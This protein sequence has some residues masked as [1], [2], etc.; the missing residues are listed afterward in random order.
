MLIQRAFVWLKQLR[1]RHNKYRIGLAGD[2]LFIGDDNLRNET[3]STPAAEE[4]ACFG[5]I[6]YDGRLPVRVL[7]GMIV[8]CRHRVR[9]DG[10]TADNDSIISLI[11]SAPRATLCRRT[12]LSVSSAA[13]AP[14]VISV[15][16]EMR[17]CLD[18]AR[19]RWRGAVRDLRACAYDES[20][21]GHAEITIFCRS[22][23]AE[24]C[25]IAC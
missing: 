24:R 4:K 17:L 3:S 12:R 21:N 6:T 16:H 7:R 20:G 13:H 10:M 23:D 5:D 22:G 2:D 18:A 1:R 25:A 14:G 15:P 9:F 19:R 11:I 8:S